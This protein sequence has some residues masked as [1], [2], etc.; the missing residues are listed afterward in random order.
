[1]SA[2][3]SAVQPPT[4][5]T[6]STAAAAA[7]RRPT[8]RHNLV[9][10]ITCLALATVVAAMSSLNVAL[11]AI[12][13]ETHATQTQLSWIIDAYSLVF[14]SL[15]LP[16]GALGDRFGRRRALLTGLV[17]FGGASAGALVTTSPGTLIGLRAL[18]G[19]GA[20][21]VMPATLSTITT[22]FPASSAPGR[23]ASGRRWRAPARW[24]GCSPRAHCCRPGPGVRCSC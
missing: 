11:P 12:A 2:S 8:V 24:S 1:M 20:A 6:P 21:L 13:R 19:V 10:A 15:L 22:T 18:L 23:S 14:A 17:I 9:L 7:G 3:A 16:A 5:P 4:P